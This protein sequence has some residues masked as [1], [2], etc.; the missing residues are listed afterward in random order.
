MGS[1]TRE[2]AQHKMRIQNYEGPRLVSFVGE[3]GSG[4]ST[5]AKYLVEHYGFT[6]VRFAGPLK[7]MLKAIGLTHAQVDGDQKEVPCELLGGRTPRFAMQ[8]LGSEWGR[9][10][11]GPDFWRNLWVDQVRTILNHG[12]RVVVDDCRFGNE[13]H[14]IRYLDGI[15]IRLDRRF[16]ITDSTH[17]SESYKVVA[18]GGVIHN[19][20]S[21]D[22]LFDRIDNLLTLASK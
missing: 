17:V 5:A 6:Y 21:K 18:N 19:L 13:D 22:C 14:A 1:V 7:D 12:G 16:P 10:C 8:T 2:L 11:I 4:K 20:G 3:I 9:D 15:H